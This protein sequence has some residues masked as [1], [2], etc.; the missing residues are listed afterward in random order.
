MT[1]ATFR[2][3]AEHVARAGTMT[4]HQLAAWEAAWE[5]ATTEQRQEFTDLWR[6]QGSPAA[7]AVAATWLAPARTIVR[8]FE[9]CHLK[10]YLCPAGVP[11]IGWGSTIIAG[12]VVR[13]GQSITQAQ[14]DAQLDA[15]LQRFYDALARAIPAVAGWPPNRAAALV[16]WTY[17]VGVRAMQDSTLRRRILAGE[18][19]AQVVAAELPRWNKA[20]GRELAGLTRRRAAEVALFV[21]QHLQQAT[22]YGNPLQ[23]PWYA[24]MDSADRAQAAR[25]CFSS[26]CAMLLQYLKPGTLAGPNGDDQYLKRV[27]QYGDTTDP[28]AQIRA[29]SSYG[30]KARFTKVA[31]FADLEQQ[32]N[33]GVPVPCGFLHRGSVSAPSGGGHWLIVVGYTKDHLVVHDPFGEADLVSGAT[34]GGVAR[35]ARYSRRNFGPRWQVEGANTGWAV[36]AER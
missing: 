31:G 34:L 15:D 29:L 14:A 13:K 7:P 6:A 3:A 16:S 2:A 21:G 23:V 4:P 27:Q 25:M 9:G 32:I 30:I 26:S 8:E 17:N 36:I 19:P 35:F 22:G 24:Q 10:A 20:D 5:R 1:F 12:K 11:T 28:T 33:R 18:D